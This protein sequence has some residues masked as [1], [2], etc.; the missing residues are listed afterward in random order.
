MSRRVKLFASILVCFLLL[1][2]LEG[3]ALAAFS[4]GDGTAGNPYIITTPEQL[5]EMRDN[6]TAHYKLGNDIDLVAYCTGDGWVPVGGFE[7]QGSFTGSLSGNGNKIIGLRINRPAS[8]NIGLFGE[9]GE[10]AM[11]KD[12]AFENVDITGKNYV[13]VLA[14]YFKG[15]GARILNVGVK[16]G[17]VEAKNGY[18]GGLAGEFGG[19]LMEYCYSFASV[20]ATATG[21][22]GNFAGGLAGYVGGNE[23]PAIVKNCYAV[24]PVVGKDYLGGLTGIAENAEFENCMAFGDVKGEEGIG[25]FVG[26]AQNFNKFTDC[27][28]GGNITIR[29]TDEGLGGGFVGSADSSGRQCEYLRCSASGEVDGFAYSGGFAGEG[30]QG[31]FT[32]CRA[33]GDVTASDH[34]LAYGGGF[35]ESLMPGGKIDRCYATGETTAGGSSGA[36]AGGLVSVN[37]GGGEIVNSYARGNISVPDSL[38]ATL[39][40]LVN[41]NNGTITNCFSTGV[42]S[43]DGGGLVDGPT[44]MGITV[45]SSYYDS[46][47]SRKTD[48][49]QGSKG[50]STAEMKGGPG[51]YTGWNF[52][53]TWDIQ[54]SK[55]DGYPH[56]REN[57]P[58]AP[59]PTKPVTPGPL[60]RPKGSVKVTITGPAEARW[61]LDNEGG[62]A[63]GHT[64]ENVPTGTHTISFSPVEGWDKPADIPVTVIRGATATAIGKYHSHSTPEPVE[65]PSDAPLPDDA[66]PAKPVP[67]KVAPDTPEDQKDDAMKDVLKGE[68]TKLH[69]NIADEL[70]D[71]D[72]LELD[73]EGHIRL[74]SDGMD[75]MVEKLND[76]DIP[77]EPKK[78]SLPV[79]RAEPAGDAVGKLV[80]V[81]FKI[82]GDFHGMRA[83][84]VRAIKALGPDEAAAFTQVFDLEKLEDG[85]SA[86]VEVVEENGNEKYVKKLRANETINANCRLALAIRDGSKF[87]LDGKEDGGV[88]D[89]CFMV[90]VDPNASPGGGGSGGGCSTFGGGASVLLLLLPLAALAFGRK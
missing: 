25:G 76:P 36:S 32:L 15:S 30:G 33:T 81:F 19:V 57:D 72:L 48:T 14:G 59:N 13:G 56:L 9:T 43:G 70:V 7:S 86:I 82:P 10:D 51:V 63:S 54:G 5:N 49:N 26:V 16:S 8:D 89:P 24:G 17:S 75:R 20:T 37:N 65:P 67:P 22:T 61:S 28:A 38:Q 90:E 52:T 66:K 83:E 34:M 41:T 46:T 60:P 44:D 23:D 85:C 71:E 2:L 31:Q 78:A 73:D 88:S 35:A 47:T 79:F 12:L 77:E 62:Y 87:D 58:D 50:L 3:E 4:G 42:L 18:V 40:G 21:T 11:V 84:E 80:V 45:V 53:S 64:V 1:P 39:G 68:S 27:Y 74:S 29:S 69:G 6:L 55:N